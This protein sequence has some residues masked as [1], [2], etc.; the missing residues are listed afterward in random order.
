MTTSKDLKQLISETIAQYIEPHLATDFVT[1]KALKA[2][3]L[4][5][6]CATITIVLGFPAQSSFKEIE[7]A[8]ITKLQKITQLDKVALKLSVKI[9]AHGVQSG[10]TGVKG[11]KNIIAIA[12]GKGGVGKSTTAV[13]LALGLQVQ[14]ARV[15]LL[16]A[17]IYGPNAPLMLGA[18][19]ERPESKAGKYLI[20]IKCHGIQSMS[21]G[22]LI[23]Q[24]DT[25]MIWR[26]PMV[27]NALQQLLNDTLWGDLD[28]LLIDL[29]PGTGDIQLTLAQKIP[30]SGALI[31][32]TPQ[33]VAL[34]D[35]RKGLRMFE[36]V[37]I[38]VL[39]IIE[40]M[41][42]YTCPSCGHQAPIFGTGGGQAMAKQYGINLLG[43]LPLATEI[44]EQSDRGVPIVIAQ[45]DSKIAQSY[46]KIAQTV[47]AR[48]S[49][50]TKNYA[51]KFP[52][53]VVENK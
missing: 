44:R 15:G 19:T 47:A 32:T 6:D 23:E 46:R 24:N 40:N 52:K 36:K 45:P 2:I 7:A 8:L 31:V 5:D 42:L 13:N 20:P 21:I 51:S 37:K 17:D 29:P 12:S 18:A 49:L 41:S 38:P 14:G 53:I 11:V 25:P 28:Y 9:E 43:E 34:L 10:L 39:G 1:A 26:G 30:V 4:N 22:Y 33:D 48:L 27:T 3:E 16:D 35:A 50:Q